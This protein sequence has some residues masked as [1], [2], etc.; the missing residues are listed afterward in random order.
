MEEPRLKTGISSW[1]TLVRFRHCLLL[2]FAV[3]TQ[4]SKLCERKWVIFNPLIPESDQCQ[5]D[6]QTIGEENANLPQE[7]TGGLVGGGI[8]GGGV[9]FHAT[10]AF[11]IPP[12]PSSL[13]PLSF[14]LP[15]LLFLLLL[16]PLTLLLLPPSSPSLLLVQYEEL[17]L[18]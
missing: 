8:G 5:L 18:S 6:L 10:P 4:T 13:L 3:R 16:S 7:G 1:G 12:P 9:A 2:P 15:L 17:C 11:P 14:L